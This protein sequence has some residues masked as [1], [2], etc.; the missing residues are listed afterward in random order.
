MKSFKFQQFEIQQ[1]KEVFRVGTDAVLLGA[2]VEVSSFKNI[3]EIGV[4][5]GIISLMIAQRNPNAQIMSIDINEKAYELAKRNFDNSIFSD[6]LNL[7]LGD[8]THYQFPDKTSF[9]LIVSNPPYFDENNSSKDVV[10]RQKI[11]LNFKQLIV[12]SVKYLSDN[13]QL[14]IIIPAQ[15]YHEVYDLAKIHQLF[16]VRQINIFGIA[17]GEKKRLILSFSKKQSPLS[18]EDFIIEKSPRNYSDSYLELTK[19]FHVFSK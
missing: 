15:F 1:S 2:M 14:S 7:V 10:A 17:G 19:E 5:T 12:N 18:E 13:G 3:L 11:K 8:F 6:R 4:G 16:L 9:D